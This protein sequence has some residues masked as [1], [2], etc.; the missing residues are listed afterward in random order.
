MQSELED[1][2]RVRGLQVA[3]GL[4]P[5][6]EGLV[7]RSQDERVDMSNVGQVLV[8]AGHTEWGYPYE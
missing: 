6:G 4:K 7:L 1:F 8:Q 5:G 3:V 2:F